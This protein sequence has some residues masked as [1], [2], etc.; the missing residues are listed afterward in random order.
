M[1][2]NVASREMDGELQ[3]FSQKDTNLPEAFRDAAFALKVGEVSDAV[4]YDNKF[5]LIK[6]EERLPPVAVK[7][8]DVEGSLRQTL[9]ENIIE[10]MVKQLRDQL[11]AQAI[12]E[13]QIT[14][15]IM[16]QQYNERKAE[17]EAQVRDQARIKA[18]MDADA[19]ACWIGSTP[20]HSRRPRRRRS[21]D[22][23]QLSANDLSNCTHLFLGA[24][25]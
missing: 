5:F 7:F 15:P 6:M 23:R 19:F 12:K 24:S 14:D 9:M 2:E 21:L 8:E 22:R 11:G 4:E 16:S 13:M 3:P 25:P 1:S 17:Q 20:P 18:D 10:Q